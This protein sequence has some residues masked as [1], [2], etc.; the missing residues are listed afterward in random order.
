MAS[1]GR[2]SEL[3]VLM[4]D[5][6]YIHFKPKVAGVMLYFSPEFMRNNQK[7]NQVNDPWYIPAVPTGKSEFGPPN[8]P[9]R[10]L[11]YYYRY[12]MEHPELRKDRRRLFVPIK[13]NN[14]GKEP[15]A[16]TISRWICTTIVDSHA[17]IQNSKSFSRSVKAH[18]VRAVAA[19]LQLFNKVD[20]QAVLKAGRWSSCG[21][22]TSFYL[23]DL[24]PHTDSLRRKGPVVAAGNIVVIS[25][26]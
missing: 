9:V 22:F 11:R 4:F 2:R 3:Q 15:S 14:A 20:L 13:D 18:E 19:S 5:Q 24:C 8:C 26:S 21:T 7:P 16:A 12:C 10:A 17:A 23:G 6:N 25:S 1:A